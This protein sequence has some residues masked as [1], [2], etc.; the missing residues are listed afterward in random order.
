MVLICS[1][2]EGVYFLY[3]HA[4]PLSQFTQNLHRTKVLFSLRDTTQILYTRKHMIEL[5]RNEIIFLTLLTLL[6]LI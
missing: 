2:Q 1:C 4:S 3:F 6:T 5:P